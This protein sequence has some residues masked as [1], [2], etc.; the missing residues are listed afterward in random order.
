MATLSGQRLSASQFTRW[1]RKL[2]ASLGRPLFAIL[3]AV[4]AGSIVIMI[5]SPGSLVD[6]FAAVITAYQSLYIGS[7]GDLQSFS[8]TL[9]RVGPLILTGISVALAFRAGLFNIGAEG[10][11]AV[12]AM[13]AGIIAFKLPTWPGWV[14]IPLMII[15][16]ML[17]GAIWGGIV[18]I[19]KAWR[20]AHEVVSTIMLNWIGLYVI[21]YLVDGPFHKPTEGNQT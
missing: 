21:D 15:S 18:G 14:L 17:A 2:G 12:G 19:L 1:L 16:S 9:V 3:L 6:R 4:I 20:A 5:T 10:Q 7:L 8:S 13:T 11:L